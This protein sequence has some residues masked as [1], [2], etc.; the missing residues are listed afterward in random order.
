VQFPFSGGAFGIGLQRAIFET[1][2]SGVTIERLLGPDDLFDPAQTIL[3]YMASDNGRVI[4][5]LT[6]PIFP[7]RA[8]YFEL[9]ADGSV[10]HRAGYPV[11]RDIDGK[12]VL[13]TELSAPFDRRVYQNAVLRGFNNNGDILIWARDLGTF[14]DELHVVT[15]TGEDIKL[16]GRL[17]QV[18]EQ[19]VQQ[20][21]VSTGG[22]CCDMLNNNGDVVVRADYQ[23]G[24]K[25]II[26]FVSANTDTEPPNW[27]VPES[28]TVNT[29]PGLATA[30]VPYTATATD[31]VGVTSSSCSPASESTFDLGDTVVSCTASDAAGNTA[32]ASFTVTVVDAELPVWDVPANIVEVATGL[33]GATVTY[34]ATAT[35][36]VGIVGE[37]CS[38]GS[39]SEFPLG[40]TVVQCEASDAAG[41]QT[42]ASFLVSIAVDGN[43]V[44]TLSSGISE[45]ELGNGVEQSL[46]AELRQIERL[47]TDGNPDNDAAI[48]DKL[49]EFLAKVEQRLTDGDISSANASL[50]TEFA[51]ALKA[52]FGCG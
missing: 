23:S 3:R 41:N 25:Q 1:S 21:S 14:L 13:G 11:T 46:L 42:S 38:P 17:D 51:L 37:T 50:L 39:G 15:G 22:T 30:V 26:K 43:S 4:Y 45:L 27:N 44:S 48:C 19:T 5:E 36:N 8:G 52:L 7:G 29:D 32:E 10:N 47:L 33:T 6:K 12:L 35:D 40:D 20:L 34:T 24:L 18:G 16:I 9:N 2:L 28:F 31:N 49:D